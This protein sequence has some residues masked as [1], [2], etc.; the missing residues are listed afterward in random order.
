MGSIVNGIMTNGFLRAFGATFFN[1]S[2]YQRPAVRMASIMEVPSIFL[3]T[4]DSVLLGEDGPT[5]EPVEHLMS[6]RAM[7]NLI[8]MRPGDANET[9]DAWRWIMSNWKE[10]VA[11]VLSRQKVPVLD[12]SAR[13]G[14]FSRG[15]YILVDA[16]GGEPD[17]ILIGTGSELALCVQARDEL[18]GQGVKTRVVSFPSWE[19]FERQPRDY[20]DKVLPPSVTARVSVEAGATLAWCKWVGHRGVSIGIDRFGASAPAAV[21]AEKLGLTSQNVVQH[22][23]KLLGK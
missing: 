4:H 9:A 8:T 21:I 16:D 12:R 6:L 17:V 14:D 13:D 22:A 18:N 5:H 20:Q 19:L 1:F 23:L 11:L 7:P 15:A 10:P 3:Y 2:D